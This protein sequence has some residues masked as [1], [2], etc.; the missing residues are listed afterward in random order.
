MVKKKFGFFILILIAILTVGVLYSLLNGKETDP[1]DDLP[2]VPEPSESD[3]K[4]GDFDAV[5]L[6]NQILQRSENGM[7][8][9]L[10]F[11]A[12]ETEIGEVY[13]VLGEPDRTDHHEGIGSF[14]QYNQYEVS[15]GYKEEIV[16]DLRSYDE[17]LQKI[18]Y[19]TLTG[20]LGAADETKYYKDSEHDQTI[21]IYHVNEKYH[22]KWIL[23]RPDD[24]NPNPAVHH[25]SVVALEIRDRNPVEE[26]PM[27]IAEQ[28]QKMTLEEKIG[29]MIFAGVQGTKPN[30]KAEQ[31]VA[32][33]K[34]GGIILNKKN[35]INPA[36]TVAYINYLKNENRQNSIPLFFGIDQEGGSIAK[37]PGGL[38][39][40]P[41]NQKIGEINNPAFSF[42]IGA[43]LGKI[44]DAYGFNMN[45]APVLDVN[46]NPDNPVIGDR[47][48]GDN[49][50]VVSR[51]GI[52]T[53]KG[54]QSK[55]IISVIKHFPGHGDTSVDSH[56]AL[57]TVHKTKSALEKTEL[58]PF[59]K[60]LAEGADV[61]MVGHILFPDLDPVYPSSMSKVIIDGLLRNELGF[62]GVVIT[63]DMT[64]KAITGNFDIGRAAVQSVLAGSDIIM[65]AHEHKQMI[66]VISALKSAVHRGEIPEERLNESVTRI[67]ELKKKYNLE[68]S[69]RGEVLI[70]EYNKQI[71]SVLGKY[72]N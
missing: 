17:K 26:P 65:V 41:T 45:F 2:D 31:L 23:D 56:L 29:Q 44:V 69:I 30:A 35:M 58:V 27:T 52:E 12:G 16:F 66:A 32:K 8:L 47:S 42:E 53:M 21:L 48:F 64:M 28:V 7:L 54:L 67:L 39:P 25:I 33:Y 68:D 15:I 22:L 60:A 3:E 70:N 63:D 49:P 43:L 51:L 1:V 40:F 13:K 19:D 36:Q 6:I 50:E 72:I 46:S 10:P 55:N 20:Y 71:N 57:P 4:D 62:N 14:A 11:A 34:V 9:E 5:G 38:K 37:L 59:K 18:H 61:V 24:K